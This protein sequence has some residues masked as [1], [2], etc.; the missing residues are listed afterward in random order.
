MTR[1]FAGALVANG[2]PHR[3]LNKF[4][5]PRAVQACARRG[6]RQL[7]APSV[8]GVRDPRDKGLAPC[9]A[10]RRR[11]RIGVEMERE[12]QLSSSGARKLAYESEREQVEIRL[13]RRAGPSSSSI[14]GRNRCVRLRRVE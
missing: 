11:H 7:E 8:T 14:A 1:P 6:Q 5:R 4:S 12:G 9:V 3:S 13:G 2:R 10:A